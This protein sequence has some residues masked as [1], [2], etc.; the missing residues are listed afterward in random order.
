MLFSGRLRGSPAVS[1]L[2]VAAVPVAVYA[3]GRGV[4]GD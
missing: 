4:G 3:V 1:G 2:R